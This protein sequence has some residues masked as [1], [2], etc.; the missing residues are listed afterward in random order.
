[1]GQKVNPIIQRIGYLRWWNSKWFSAKKYQEFLKQDI[2]IKE[3]LKKRL[4]EAG[5]AKIEIKRVQNSLE[6]D[7][8]T[9]KPGLVI[10]RAGRGAEE[11]KKE[12]LTK[13]F[14]KI[15]SKK[16][17]INLNLN[18][19][20]V[21][22][23]SHNAELIVQSIIADLEKRVPYRR[24]MKQSL[25]R[26]EKSGA[27]GAKL[28]IS[29]RLNGIEIAR[30]EHLSFGE[31]PLHTLRSDIDYAFGIAHT[32][33]GVLGVKAWIYKG[34]IFVKKKETNN[35]RNYEKDTKIR[36]TTD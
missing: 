12:L 21:T 9:S 19:Q 16:E 6:I 1:M 28:M 17:P 15:L 34:E 35:L 22:Q 31:M 20:E 7:I 11:L 33:Y 23:P 2:L 32:T 29:G 5:V 10:G 18:I 14:S 24:I 3:F 36:K 4:R 25:N 8:F 13:F 26:I 30:S 27:K